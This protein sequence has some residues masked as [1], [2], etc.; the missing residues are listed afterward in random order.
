MSEQYNCG[1]GIDTVV[2]EDQLLAT[3]VF[4]QVV[5]VIRFLLQEKLVESIA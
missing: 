2:Y 5:R 1:D 4:S 3:T